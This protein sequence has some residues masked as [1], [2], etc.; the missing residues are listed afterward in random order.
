MVG[1]ICQRMSEHNEIRFERLIRVVCL[2]CTSVCFG[3]FVLGGW[4]WLVF[5]IPFGA[6][7]VWIGWQLLQP[8]AWYQARI[9]R[10]KHFQKSHPRFGVILTVIGVLI[11]AILYLFRI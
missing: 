9:D 2:C 11:V 1:I 10:L 7:A 3:M 5:S 6:L 8:D 4:S